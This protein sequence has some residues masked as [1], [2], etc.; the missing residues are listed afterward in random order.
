MRLKYG[1]LQVAAR[2][3][4]RRKSRKVRKGR[5]DAGRRPRTGSEAHGFT[6]VCRSAAAASAPGTNEWVDSLATVYWSARVCSILDLSYKV[7]VGKVHQRGLRARPP[8][9]KGEPRSHDGKEKVSA[10]RGNR[11]GSACGGCVQQQRRRD[12]DDGRRWGRAPACSRCRGAVRDRTGFERRRGRRG[13]GGGGG[14]ED[15]DG[16][17]AQAQNFER[18]RRLHDGNG[19]CAGRS[20]R[21]GPLRLRP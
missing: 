19:E 15:G 5:T 8:K 13:G 6:A 1:V 12:D 17:L 16:S 7:T 3:T 9:S 14:R 21:T 18:Q 2:R 20:G 10:D 4:A 11:G